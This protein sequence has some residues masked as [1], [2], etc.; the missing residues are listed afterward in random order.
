MN[1]QT[2]IIIPVYNAENTIERCVE[3]LIFGKEK[4]IQIILINDCSTDGSWNKCQELDKKYGCVTSIQ[5]SE[6][7]GVSYARNRGLELAQGKYV[8]FVDSDDWVSG[9]Y[10]F[11]LVSEAEINEDSFIVCGYYYIDYRDPEKKAY[12][13]GEINQGNVVEAKDFFSL[14]KSV[15]LNQLWNKIFRRN[16]IEK[17]HIR[18]DENQSMGEDFQFVLEYMEAMQC[19]QCVILNEPLYYY[20]RANNSALMSQFGLIENGN[21][22]RHLQKLLK[23]SGENIVEVQEQYNEAIENT[24][25]NYIYFIARAK[26]KNINEKLSMIESVMKNG[27]AKTYYCQQ[28]VIKTKEDI[29]ASIDKVRKTI[30]RV[31]RRARREKRDRLV[32]KVRSFFENKEVSIISQNCIAG[33]F[34]NDMQMQFLSPTINLYFDCP[35]FVRFVL[36]LQY[37]V[38]KELKM[39]W[40]EEYPIGVIEDIRIHFMHYQTC[41][42]AKVAWERRCKRLNWERIF[43]L[44]TDMMNFSEEL[45]EKWKCIQ[46]P[47]ILFSSKKWEDES[48]VWYPEYEKNGKVVDL[49]P[50]REF[51]KDNRLISSVNRMTDS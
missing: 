43:V 29:I 9:N 45:F 51:Y 14:S 49:I 32:K 47:K 34:Y 39:E 7:R 37:Y 3:S 12:L 50:K 35:D 38:G 24:K 40:G 17:S 30:E 33:V 42:E 44:S 10:L 11:R 4:D 13:Y 18:F 22:Y 15:L 26:N 28:K 46:Y 16:I 5:N 1:A 19:K 2:S 23:L 6:N 48:C 41:T 25:M 8:V 20:V 27:Q 31:K 21:E 36:N